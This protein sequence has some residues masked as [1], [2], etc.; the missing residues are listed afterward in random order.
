MEEIK[1]E[2]FEAAVIKIIEFKNEDV[3][4]TSGKYD[5]D[6]EMPEMPV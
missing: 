6:I 5:N 2:K 3:I 4:T 1:K